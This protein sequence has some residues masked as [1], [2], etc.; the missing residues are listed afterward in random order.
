ML[1]AGV[2]SRARL[3][4]LKVCGKMTRCTV[5]VGVFSLI[6]GALLVIVT[7]RIGGRQEGE[8]VDG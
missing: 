6:K 4:K 7:E 1:S 8:K 5:M 2:K 3:S